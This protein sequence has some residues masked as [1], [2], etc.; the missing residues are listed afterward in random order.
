MS[1]PRYSA[2]V[3]QGIALSRHHGVWPAAIPGLGVM[4]GGQPGGL[5]L[6]CAPM[7]HPRTSYT[8]VVYGGV[9]VCGSCARLLA[10]KAG[11][12]VEEMLARAKEP[13]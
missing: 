9:H 2:G 1:D 12:E 4:R 3:I 13:A 6:F 5:C 8:W 10:S 11:P 7:T